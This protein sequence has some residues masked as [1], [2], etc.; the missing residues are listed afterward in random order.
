MWLVTVEL[1]F[2]FMHLSE[3]PVSLSHFLSCKTEL[4]SSH[5]KSKIQNQ[6]IT[7]N[8]P[9]ELHD[10]NTSDLN[11]KNARLLNILHIK[12]YNFVFYA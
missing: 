1:T 2:L 5:K 8:S 7:K 12:K 9:D 11:K 3:K 4:V 6:N 10:F